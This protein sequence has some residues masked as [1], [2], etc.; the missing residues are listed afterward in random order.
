M[1]KWRFYRRLSTHYVSLYYIKIPIATDSGPGYGRIP[2][3]LRIVVE[4]EIRRVDMGIAK[5]YTLHKLLCG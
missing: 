1:P 4:V 2:I 3:D 5:I